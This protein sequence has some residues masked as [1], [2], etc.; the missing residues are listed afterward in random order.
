MPIQCTGILGI[1]MFTCGQFRLLISLVCV[2]I[3]VV[4]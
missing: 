4:L 3:A 1:A 2:T